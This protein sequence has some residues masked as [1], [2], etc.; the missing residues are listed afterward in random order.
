[1]N[2]QATKITACIC[3]TIIAVAFLG[4]AIY[5]SQTQAATTPNEEVA[6]QLKEQNRQ[7][8]RIAASLEI[9]SGQHTGWKLPK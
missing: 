8:A 7:L 6:A 1:M 5:P 9:I 4:L 3:G 2:G